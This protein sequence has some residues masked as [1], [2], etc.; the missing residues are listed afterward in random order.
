MLEQHLEKLVVFVG[1]ADAGSIRKYALS[2]RLSQPGVSQRVS[3]LERQVG[4]SLFNRSRNGIQLTKQGRMV[5]ELGVALIQ[6]THAVETDLYRDSEREVELKLGT[7]DSVAIYLIPNVITE[8]Q[9]RLP[10]LRIKLYCDRSTVIAQKVEEGLLDL[11]LCA[12]PKLSR[13]LELTPLYEDRYGFYIRTTSPRNQTLI[14][15]SD[16][17]DQS[18]KNLG[19]YIRTFGLGSFHV[20]NV[21]SFEVAKAMTLAGLG[22]G[23]LPHRV[24]N[25]SVRVGLLK[26][27]TM[28]A[29]VATSFGSHSFGLVR[30]KGTPDSPELKILFEALAAEHQKQMATE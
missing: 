9:N 8:L 5:Y 20:L 22:V 7:Y 28:P 29:S 2:R 3:A 11:G 27:A 13:R 6:K 1:V 14:T 30:R 26:R 18:G 15:V 4:F 23:V 17:T 16:A 25:Q 19:S 21:P 24:A 12:S 10:N